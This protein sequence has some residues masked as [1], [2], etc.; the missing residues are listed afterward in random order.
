MFSKEELGTILNMI[1]FTWQNGGVRS[2]PQAMAFNRLK[3]KTQN[4]IENPPPEIPVTPTPAEKPKKK[5]G[6]CGG[7]CGNCGDCGNKKKLVE[8][9]KGPP[10]A[11]PVEVDE[12][13]EPPA[14]ER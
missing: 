11:E 7:D 8:K 13:V 12:P 5:C 2:E 3:V 6:K 9:P 10:E 1:D 4:M 14:Q